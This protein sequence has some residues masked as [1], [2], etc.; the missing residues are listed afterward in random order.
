MPNDQT[1]ANYYF[2]NSAPDG[3][4]TYSLPASGTASTLTDGPDGSAD[5][6]TAIGDDLTWS[7]NGGTTTLYGFTSNGDPIVETNFGTSGGVIHVFAGRDLCRES[8]PQ[9]PY[10]KSTPESRSA[11][12]LPDC[13][14]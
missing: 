7:A 9:S 8:D 2:F 3:S 6:S 5:G 4:T 12:H 11:N 14:P 1:F 10:L 13:H